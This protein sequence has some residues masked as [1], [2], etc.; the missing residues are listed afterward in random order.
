MPLIIVLTGWICY[1][2]FT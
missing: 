1:Y 2:L